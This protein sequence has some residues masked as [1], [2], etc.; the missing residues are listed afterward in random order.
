MV[1]VP[2]LGDLNRTLVKVDLVAVVLAALRAAQIMHLCLEPQIL[3]VEVVLE[4]VQA[5]LV[6][7]VLVLLSLDI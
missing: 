4:K 7:V 6:M 2:V 3:A 1:A 5:L